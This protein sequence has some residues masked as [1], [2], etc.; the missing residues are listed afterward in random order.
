MNSY[1]RNYNFG[2]L[3]TDDR[4]KGNDKVD[5]Y[6]FLQKQNFLKIDTKTRNK[7]FCYEKQIELKILSLGRSF[8]S[9]GFF[10]FPPI[11]VYIWK[12]I[13][14]EIFKQGKMYSC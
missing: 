9:N 4:L 8:V 5:K 7:Q 1:T 13:N 6:I 14:G 10:D 12:S 2:Y 3:S 11:K